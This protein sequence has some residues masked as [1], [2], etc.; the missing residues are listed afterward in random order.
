MKIRRS[1]MT[2]MHRLDSTSFARAPLFH[3]DKGD[4]T[5]SSTERRQIGDAKLFGIS[6]RNSS[7]DRLRTSP[8]AAMRFAL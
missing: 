6:S 4:A 1:Q 5:G 7:V 2:M 3:L 8:V